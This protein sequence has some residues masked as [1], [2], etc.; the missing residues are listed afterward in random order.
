MK[1][2]Q[3]STFLRR[4]FSIAALAS[5]MAAAGMAQ[6]MAPHYGSATQAGA[7][8]REIRIEPGTKWVNVNRNETVRFVS[9]AS[10]KSFVW[11]FDTLGTP[12]FDFGQIAPNGVADQQ[13]IRVFVA[14]D[15]RYVGA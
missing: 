10:G 6:A 7:A 14:P 8:E 1:A 12:S 3:S 15:P 11:K 2:K 4:S 13:R 5:I 9:T